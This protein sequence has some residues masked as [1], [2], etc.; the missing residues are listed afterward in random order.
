MI[1]ESKLTE[2][3]EGRL[4]PRLLIA[5]PA[6]N[7]EKTVG[8]VIGQIPTKFEGI[9]SSEV[10]VIDDGS[11]DQTKS[12]SEAAGAR[13][14]S[15]GERCGVGVAFQTALREALVGG[16]DLLVMMDSDG[17][18]DPQNLPKLLGPVLAGKA[19]FTTASRFIDSSLV[20]EMPRMK[21]WGNR[22]M[23]RIVS[24][25]TRKKYY[26]VSCGFRCYSRVAMLSLNL[27]GD[28]TYTQEV[29]L[30]LAFKKL[31]V[32]E[33]AL[34]VKGEREFGES[35]VASNLFKYAWRAS[36]IIIRS[37]RDYRPLRFFGTLAIL[38]LVPAV[39]LSL[40]LGGHYLNSGSF[41]PHKWAGFL[42]GFFF[43]FGFLLLTVGM[44]SD[45]LTRH[46]LYLEE[47]LFRQRA[48]GSLSFRESEKNEAS[49]GRR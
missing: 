9:A 13:V 40:F 1:R 18:F 32:H 45:M 8:T 33:V 4:Q 29:F 5:L 43:L 41:T 22:Q 17:Q 21:L 37:Y 48:E 46:R 15:H 11:E 6:L 25:L 38:N 12:L 14:I 23:S 24:S 19:D 2:P 49:P 27:T 3:L 34:R 47:I 26:D 36:S 28:F 31:R 30:N 44:V 7:E 10:V 39:L 42:S 16:Y 35:R 20:P